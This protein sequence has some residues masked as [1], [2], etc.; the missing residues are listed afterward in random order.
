MLSA[1]ARVED[2]RVGELRMNAW[3]VEIQLEKSH[4]YGESDVRC[5]AARQQKARAGTEKKWEKGK[6]GFQSK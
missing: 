1:A 4:V 5:A 6:S 3:L 2:R